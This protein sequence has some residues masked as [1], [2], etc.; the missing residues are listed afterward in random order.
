MSHRGLQKWLLLHCCKSAYVVIVMISIIIVIACQRSA[1][2]LPSNQLTELLKGEGSQLMGDSEKV[3]PN[4]TNHPTKH[5]K[6]P[7]TAESSQLMRS[8][9]QNMTNKPTKHSKSPRPADSNQF[10]TE[11]ETAWVNAESNQFK[12]KSET[13]WVNAESNQFKRESETAWVNAESNQFKGESETAWVNAESNQFKRESETAWVN[14]ESN[15]FKRES[16]TA[17]VN[18]ESNQFKGESETAWVNA[19]GNQFK[20]ESETAWVEVGP[21]MFVFSAYLDTRK[22][23]YYSKRGVVALAVQND[24]MN[25]PP[26]VY[27]HLTDSN[28]RTWCLKHHIS[29]VVLNR[30]QQYKYRPYYYICNL[31][32]CFSAI[33]PKFVSFSF[34]SSCQQPSPPVPVTQVQNTTNSTRGFGVCIQSPLF[35]MNDVQ[36]VIQ[37]IE[38]NRILGA[39]WFTF[40]IH[41]ASQDIMRVLQDYSREGV[42]DVV[43]S[44]IPNIS[45]HYYG[46]QVLIQDCAYRNMYKIRHL[47]YTDLDEIIVPQKHQKWSQMITAIDR[48]F[49]GGFHVRHVTLV[50]KTAPKTL[51][52]CDSSKEIERPRFMKFTERSSPYHLP[53]RAKYIIKPETFAVAQTH[54][55]GQLLKG[56]SIYSVPAKVALLY[57]YR[58]PFFYDRSGKRTKDHQMNRYLPELIDRIEQRIC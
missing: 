8:S 48:K 58:F 9:E 18:A 29:K 17:W 1:V 12:R 14:A 37:T 10:K 22:N 19:E 11:S 39:E 50:G 2:L 56:Y 7:I 46:Q 27:C 35:N 32:P 36:L 4:I 6:S 28:G 47:L 30:D 42:V 54:D 49:I 43:R 24:R 41:S 15:Q 13:A 33:T 55:P 53:R 57:H 51:S 31:P 26:F 44:M 3:L 16:E 25:H 45:V 5:L 52:I 38:M 20:K 34:N 21:E 40:Y 23:Y